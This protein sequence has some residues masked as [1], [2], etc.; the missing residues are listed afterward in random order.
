M[1]RLL[2]LSLFFKHRE[3][4]FRRL[5][6]VRTKGDWE[7]WVD[8]FLDVVAMIADEAATSARELFAVVS[9]DTRTEPAWKLR[10]QR[11]TA[12]K[13]IETRKSTVTGTAPGLVHCN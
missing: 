3:E 7:G 2:Y 12:M 10:T 5:T 8:F 11:P 9:S 6:T 1:G 4:Y 13:L